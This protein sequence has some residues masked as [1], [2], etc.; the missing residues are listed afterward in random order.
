MT[1]QRWTGRRCMF[2]EVRTV[3]I[4]EE[5]IFL[6]SIKTL[7]NAHKR[8]QRQCPRRTR[9]QSQFHY[10]LA[11]IPYSRDRKGSVLTMAKT[12]LLTLSALQQR[13]CS[14]KQ[15][16]KYYR[17]IFCKFLLKKST[18]GQVSELIILK[19]FLIMI[20]CAKRFLSTTTW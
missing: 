11:D 18:P 8:M 10:F 17:N 5:I 4:S 9:F 7:Q 20:I 2:R 12:Q 16:V 3:A 15:L 14:S 1:A 13:I 6:H 19:A